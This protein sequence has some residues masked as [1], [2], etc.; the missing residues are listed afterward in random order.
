MSPATYRKVCIAALVSVCVIV[1]TGASVR[2]TG[3]GLGCKDWP[4]CNDSRFVDVSTT[5]G[6]I[7]QVNRLFT[8]VVMVAVVAA[9]LGAIRRRPR[10]RDLTR[11]A[12]VIALGV[13]MQGLVGAIVVL[14]DLNP[15]ANQQHFLLSM[16]L[17]AL[18]TVLVVRAGEPDA[19][20]RIATVG[21][22]TAKYVRAVTG[23]SALAIVT[24]T[25]VTGS[26]P[27]AGDEKAKR[28][29][30]AISSMARIHSITVLITIGAAIL[31]FRHLRTHDADRKVLEN[32]LMTWVV[33]AVAQAGIGYTQYFS[34]VPAVLVGIHVAF[35]TVLWLA[36]V[37]LQLT[38]RAVRATAAAAL[39]ELGAQGP[40]SPVASAP[41]A[42][43]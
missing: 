29:D 33:I 42:S 17:V 26:G 28:F 10:R 39:T 6:A 1:V 5:H 36:T 38:T 43:T 15:F 21:D 35:A 3:S 32:A 41:A 40:G 9:V 8:G 30:V 37:Q 12:V 20:E 13:P 16:V 23:L 19:G 18:A 2:L 31:L 34:G 22:R 27:H 24:G 7:E 11:L 4:N 25:F 14:T